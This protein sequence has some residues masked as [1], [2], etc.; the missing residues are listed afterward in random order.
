MRGRGRRDM[1]KRRDGEGSWEGG[2]DLL[3]GGT[4]EMARWP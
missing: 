1:E 2:Q 3:K 4:G